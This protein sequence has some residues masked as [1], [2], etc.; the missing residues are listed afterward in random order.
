MS[1]FLKSVVAAL[2]IVGITGCVSTSDIEVETVKSEKANLKG[3]KTYEIIKE[4]GATDEIK[5]EKTLEN[6]DI[7]ASLKKMINEELA[8]RGKVE[9][10]E[11]PDFYVAYLL[12]S[13][14]NAMRITLDK[15]GRSTIANV[16]EAAMILMLVD[17]DTGSIIWLSTAEGEYK[18]LPRE[19]KHKRMKY[20]IEKMLKGL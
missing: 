15:E 2:L 11:N 5:K 13:D 1:K 6:V 14:M 4:S 20:T 9:V 7:D 19:A 17:A 10:K 12:G 3:Y 16:P 18:S 8:K